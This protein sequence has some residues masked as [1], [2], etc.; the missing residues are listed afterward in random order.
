MVEGMLGW[1]TAPVCPHSH[2]ILKMGSPS[3]LLAGIG[4]L[5]QRRMLIQD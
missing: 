2:E 1:S 4:A 5:S 3:L